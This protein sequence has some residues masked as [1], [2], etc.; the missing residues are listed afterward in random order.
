MRS[1]FKFDLADGSVIGVKGARLEVLQ[2]T[3]TGLTYK[4]ISHF[5]R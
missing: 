2:A 1:P 5:P 3:N 4:V